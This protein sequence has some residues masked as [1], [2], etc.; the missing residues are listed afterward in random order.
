MYCTCTIQMQRYIDI[1]SYHDTLG[2]DTVLIDTHLPVGRIDIS[3]IVIYR[4]IVIKM[5]TFTYN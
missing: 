2:S 3:N 5:Y 1:L 4:C